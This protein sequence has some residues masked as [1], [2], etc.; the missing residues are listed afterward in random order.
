MFN[1]LVLLLQMY[2]IYLY[3]PQFSLWHSFLVSVLEQGKALYG[4][5][6]ERGM[7][8]LMDRAGTVFRN[9][10]KKIEK[11]DM[12]IV[13]NL[14]DLFKHVYNTLVVSLYICV[15]AIGKDGSIVTIGAVYL[16]TIKKLLIIL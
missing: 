8:V 9:G 2:F 5:G 3:N 1:I 14:V 10:K 4:V 13:P 6:T 15:C 12:S 11:F 16:R 7:C